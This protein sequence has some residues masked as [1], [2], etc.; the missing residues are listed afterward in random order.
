MTARRQDVLMNRLIFR[1]WRRLVNKKTLNIIA[2]FEID[3]ASKH[4][5][6]VVIFPDPRAKTAAAFTT[7]YSSQYT[8]PKGGKN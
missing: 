8:G 5:L 3:F 4:D 6:S 2:V 7:L 1:F